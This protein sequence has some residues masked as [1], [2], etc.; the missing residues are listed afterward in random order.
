MGGRL[1]RPEDL[2]VPRERQFRQ[3]VQFAEHIQFSDAG[4]DQADDGGFFAP[5]L[6]DEF[7][8][9]TD[10]ESVDGIEVADLLFGRPRMG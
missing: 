1:G 8:F 2:R 7:G 3:R 10:A 9:G 4:V 5:E 6:L